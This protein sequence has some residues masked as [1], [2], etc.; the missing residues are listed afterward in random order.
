MPIGRGERMS[1]LE[2][3]PCI[4]DPAQ[5]NLKEIFPPRSDGKVVLAAHRCPHGISKHLLAF[6]SQQV[7]I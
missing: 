3:K 1:V 5:S 7:S 2:S 6:G 4:E